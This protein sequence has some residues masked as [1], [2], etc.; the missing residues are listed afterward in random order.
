MFGVSKD[1]IDNMSFVI[2]FRNCIILQR[3]YSHRIGGNIDEDLKP[4]VD[5]IHLLVDS[6]VAAM[7][8]ERR[9]ERTKDELITNES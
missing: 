7:E 1:V 2:S 6:T 3:N 9:V 4:V 5:S 8:E